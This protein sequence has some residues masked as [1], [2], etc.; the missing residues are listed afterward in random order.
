MLEVEKLVSDISFKVI[1]L[2]DSGVGKT[3][4]IHQFVDSKFHDRYKATIGVDFL[5]KK[6]LIDNKC[7]RIQVFLK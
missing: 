6:Y 5:T 7:T 3:S 4:I 2:G 1:L